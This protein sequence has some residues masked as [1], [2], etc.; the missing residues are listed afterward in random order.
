M[1]L[2]CTFKNSFVERDVPAKF[3]RAAAV[4]CREGLGLYTASSPLTAW[5][6]E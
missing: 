3:V 4:F 6:E 1:L 5:R 2:D